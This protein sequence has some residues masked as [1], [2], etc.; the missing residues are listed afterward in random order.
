MSNQPPEPLLKNPQ[1]IAAIIGGLFTLIVAVVG[2]LPVILNANKPNP[3]PTPI[4]VTAT[5]IA[6]TN[7]TN[8]AEPTR[9]VT[10]MVLSPIST[11][12][13]PTLVPVAP[14]NTLEPTTIPV[15]PTDTL[16]LPS[17]TT[18]P[19]QSGNVLL[20][21]DD[22]SFTVVNQGTGTLS[23][24]GVVF[25]SAKGEWDAKRWGAT[26][27]NKLP[28]GYCLRLRDAASGQR[29]PPK[30]CSNKI[31][32]LIEAAGSALFWIGADQFDVVRNGQV[33]ATCPTST[34]SCLVNIA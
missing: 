24:E 1:I 10:L 14:T 7:P 8:T 28:A 32:G 23:L 26:I 4:I 30:P 18:V 27:Y 11:E 31:Y 2:V 5:P 21:F 20:L 33:I 16:P 15:V 12:I 22:V 34:P 3:T 6:A 29:Q 17:A 9:N 19:A 25:R 13:P